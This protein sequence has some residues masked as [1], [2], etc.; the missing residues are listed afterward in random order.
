MGIKCNIPLNTVALLIKLQKKNSL[1]FDKWERSK[2]SVHQIAHH[3]AY[4][5][6]DA[7]RRYVL[8]HKPLCAVTVDGWRDAVGVEHLLTSMRFMASGKIQ[9]WFVRWV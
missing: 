6:D 4:D 5:M 3:I 9:T 1:D 2:D 7:F 8:L